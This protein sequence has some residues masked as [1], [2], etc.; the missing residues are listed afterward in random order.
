MP[1][2]AKPFFHRGWWVTDVGG[3]RTKLAQGSENR[4]QTE[5]AFHEMLAK[6]AYAPEAKTVQQVAVWELCEQFLD[7]VK[8]HRAEKTFSDYHDWLQR[9]VKLHGKRPA[10]DI[11]PLDLEQWKATLVKSGKKPAPSTTPLSRFRPAGI[12]AFGMSCCRPTR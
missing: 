2:Q 11:R 7:W 8:I 4:K 10:R 3:Q 1:R 12:G 5:Q 9:W 6:V